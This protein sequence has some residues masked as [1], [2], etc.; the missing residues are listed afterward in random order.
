MIGVLHNNL[1]L[2]H[3]NYNLVHRFN[4]LFSPLICEVVR[5]NSAVV[6]TL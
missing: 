3:I 5:I 2:Y 4:W 1:P 6:L